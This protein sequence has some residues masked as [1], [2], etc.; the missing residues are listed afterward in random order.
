[1]RQAY[2]KQGET[3]GQA[4]CCN[5][6]YNHRFAHGSDCRDESTIAE[7]LPLVPYV[8]VYMQA[9]LIISK[10]IGRYISFAPDNPFLDIEVKLFRSEQ[11][12]HRST[13]VSISTIS[14]SVL[15]ENSEIISLTIS[16]S[17]ANIF[18]LFLH[19]SMT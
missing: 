14:Q 4:L 18:L 16:P 15:A 1:M 3:I 6:L 11:K 5:I 8:L 19:T 12:M 9:T 7:E 17:C 13:S 10:Q 2:R